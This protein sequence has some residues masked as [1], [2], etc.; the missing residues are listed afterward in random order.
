[1]LQHGKAGEK[2]G[3]YCQFSN[4]GAYTPKVAFRKDWIVEE[5]VEHF[6]T[7]SL[8]SMR[9]DELISS[10]LQKTQKKK[11]MKFDRFMSKGSSLSEFSH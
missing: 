9:K 4:S 6:Y 5:H 2:Q 10:S 3:T 8:F 7:S 1:M 11:T